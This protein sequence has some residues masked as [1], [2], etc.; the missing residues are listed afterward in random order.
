V[1]FHA[2]DYCR[3]DSIK[4]KVRLPFICI[5][6]YYEKSAQEYCTIIYCITNHKK[7]TTVLMIWLTFCLSN[8]QS[9]LFEADGR[10]VVLVL[11]LE[12]LTELLL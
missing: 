11:S 7:V 1:I 8:N 4:Y 6:L 10:V 9:E 12:Y 3:Q 5:Q 2:T